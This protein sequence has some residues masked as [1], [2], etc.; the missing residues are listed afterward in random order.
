MNAP[1]LYI[2]HGGGPL[3]ILGHPGHDELVHFLKSIVDT[4]KKPST[5][6]L[7]SAHWE[8]REPTL[9]SGARPP[10]IYDYGGFPEESYAIRYPAP[11]SPTLAESI[12][13]LLEAG[14]LSANLDDRRGFDHGLFVPLTLMYPDAQ[15]PCLQLSL[16][17]SLNPADHLE[18]G[19]ALA[20]L[21]EK[22]ILVIGS[23]MSFH[24]MQAFFSADDESSNKKCAAFDNWLIET[25]I[26]K[27]LSPQVRKERLL[28]WQDAPHGPFCHPR[29]EHLLPLHVCYGMAFAETPCA[30]LV[31]NKEVMGKRVSA[32]LW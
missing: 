21:R 29:E 16:L 19:Q 27:E 10:L 23:G 28:N 12:K 11:G 22:D 4:F 9:T 8:E 14:G 1:V 20:P 3:P 24:N 18:M 6:L 30:E 25:C 2:P 32:F 5:I 17:N 13:T 7:I 26:D 31:F 15:I